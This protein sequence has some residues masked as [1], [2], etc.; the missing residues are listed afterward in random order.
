MFL[1]DSLNKRGYC[2][3]QCEFIS[4]RDL[5]IYIFYY[6]YIFVYICHHSMFVH[7]MNNIF[8]DY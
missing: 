2:S 1:N 8:K 7:K 3:E 4:F 5:R 6:I